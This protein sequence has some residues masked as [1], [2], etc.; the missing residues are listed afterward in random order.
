MFSYSIITYFVP[1][2][3]DYNSY[4]NPYLVYQTYPKFTN[5]SFFKYFKLRSNV[6]HLKMFFYIINI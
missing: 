1:S 5:L 6:F 3:K 4:C 2:N